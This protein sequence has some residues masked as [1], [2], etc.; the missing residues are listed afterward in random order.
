MVLNLSSFQSALSRID[1][2]RGTKIVHQ[3]F[4]GEELEFKKI[5]QKLATTF[6]ADAYGLSQIKIW[7]QKFGNGDFSSEDASRSGRP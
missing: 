7:L 6:G 3:L 2:E 5:H 4:L 1:R